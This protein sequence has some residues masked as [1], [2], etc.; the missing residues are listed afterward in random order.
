MGPRTPDEKNRQTEKDVPATPQPEQPEKQRPGD[1][2]G[3]AYENEGEGVPQQPEN[4]PRTDQNSEFEPE[5]E[6]RSPEPD[7]DTM[8]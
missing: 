7:P 1:E 8:R 3:G 5:I 2:Q 6:R 4:D